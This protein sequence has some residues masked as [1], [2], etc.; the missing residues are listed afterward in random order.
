MLSN[1]LI[2]VKILFKNSFLKFLSCESCDLTSSKLTE[3]SFMSKLILNTYFF[4]KRRLKTLSFVPFTK[5]R[6]IDFLSK[7]SSPT[8]RLKALSRTTGR[9]RS[10]RSTRSSTTRTL[11]KKSNLYFE[12]ATPTSTT[13]CSRRSQKTGQICRLQYF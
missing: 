1:K 12:S 8:C 10:S 7:K 4:R 13:S 9:K 5:K 11:C 2:F 3:L 6:R